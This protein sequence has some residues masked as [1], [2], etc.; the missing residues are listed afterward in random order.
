MKNLKLSLLTGCVLALGVISCGK[1]DNNP[2]QV[3]ITKTDS[4]EVAFSATAPYTFFNFKN[5]AIIAN[6]DSASTKWDVGIRYV[7]I[8][9]NSHFSG[10]GNGGIITQ[11]GIY[12]NYT[13]A[14]T[15]GYAYDTTATQLGVNA[16][17]PNGWYNYD[18]TTH[19]FSPKA[20][21]FFVIRTADNHYVKMEILSVGYLKFNGPT[22]VTLIYRFRY[23]YKADGTTTLQ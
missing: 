18:P 8:I 20:G 11:T 3:L 9:A 23:T 13:T 10:P 2:A 21:I 1:K 17:Y 15:T 16:N 22:P 5:D 6:T 19:N 14:P 12:D 4:L 7:N